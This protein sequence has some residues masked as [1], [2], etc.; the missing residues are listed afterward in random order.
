MSGYSFIECWE[1]SKNETNRTTEKKGE[2]ERGNSRKTLIKKLQKELHSRKHKLTI[3]FPELRHCKYICIYTCPGSV[4]EN[5]RAQATV[6]IYFIGFNHYYELQW[7]AY[8]GLQSLQDHQNNRAPV[9]NIAFI[10][11][12]IKVIHYPPK[13]TKQ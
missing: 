7:M 11:S 1:V 4:G 12:P 2:N 13:L 9:L 3:I 10:F 6:F 8:A 5:E